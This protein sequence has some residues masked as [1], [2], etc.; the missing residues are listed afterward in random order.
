MLF[1]E[2]AWVNPHDH[3]VFIVD[4]DRR[5]CEALTE[6]LST[7]DLHAVTF[8]SAAEY[9]AYPKPDVPACL[10][11][12]VQLPDINGLD[13]LNHAGQR[14]NP[15][16]VFI[17]G[18]GDS[19]LGAREKL[20][21]SEA[22]ALQRGFVLRRVMERSSLS[23]PKSGRSS[24]ALRTS[25]KICRTM[26][27]SSKLVR[28]PNETPKASSN[29]EADDGVMVFGKAT[30]DSEKGVP[31]TAERSRRW[32]GSP[33]E[34]VK[35][36]VLW[37]APASRTAPRPSAPSAGAGLSPL[38]PWP[39]MPCDRRRNAPGDRTETIKQLRITIANFKR[40]VEQILREQKKD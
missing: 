14:P 28:R 31:P 30:E 34:L 17:T 4:D 23:L 11:L 18:H 13:L 15:Q 16:I 35:A 26:S 9:L 40:E 3:V 27:I 1:C 36:S 32:T 2:S 39:K 21:I 10:V 22:S 7:F 25:S 20:L 8:G 24:R 5:I 33:E 6:L 29:K 38:R 37:P 19:H 12:D